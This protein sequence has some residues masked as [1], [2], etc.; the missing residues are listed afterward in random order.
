M[1]VGKATSGSITDKLTRDHRLTLDEAHMIL[2][3]KKEDPLE[4]IRAVS[5]ELLSHFP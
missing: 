3:T 2:N 4:Q 1:G 5:A